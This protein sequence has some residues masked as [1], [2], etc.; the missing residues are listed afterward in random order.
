MKELKTRYLPQDGIWEQFAGRR[1]VLAKSDC[2]EQKVFADNLAALR[3][4]QQDGFELVCG[5]EQAEPG[6]L[7]ILFA[8]TSEGAEAWEQTLA[9]LEQLQAVKEHRPEAVLLL[10]GNEVYG[11]SFGVSCPQKEDELGY[12]CHTSQ[13]DIPAQC[14]RT[15]EHFACRLAA[16]EQIP[17]RIARIGELPSGEELHLVLEAAARVLLYGENGSIYN[18][19]ST[20]AKSEEVS[21]DRAGSPLIPSVLVTD[22]EKSER[23]GK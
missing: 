7:V 6:D 20:G 16:E 14:M 11:K 17:V 8:R 5:L 1:I 15:A 12:I 4:Q 2:L 13:T 10:S 18:L 22:T 23:L 3:T 21:A 19:P 9:L